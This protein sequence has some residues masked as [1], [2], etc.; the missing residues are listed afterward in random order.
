MDDTS[1]ETGK[2]TLFGKLDVEKKTLDNT[3]YR[4]KFT[5]DESCCF[6]MSI[7]LAPIVY[8]FY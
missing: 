3:L 1:A 4:G 2:V 6:I 8:I 7:M 5:L